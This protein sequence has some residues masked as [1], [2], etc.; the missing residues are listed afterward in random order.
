MG[1]TGHTEDGLAFEDIT[2]AEPEPEPEPEPEQGTINSAEEYEQHHLE[3][4]ETVMT[5]CG[6]ARQDPNNA[7]FDADVCIK[8]S[9][10]PNAGLG[11][12]A[13]RNFK[14][15]EVACIYPVHLIQKVK[16]GS[17]KMDL[18]C[19]LSNWIGVA[20][21]DDD[22]D[23]LK[24]KE[25]FTIDDVVENCHEYGVNVFRGPTMDILVRHDPTLPVSPK[26]YGGFLNDNGFRLG[27]VYKPE[28]NNCSLGNAQLNNTCRL[29]VVCTQDIKEGDELCHSY[30]SGYWFGTQEGENHTKDDQFKEKSRSWLMKREVPFG[31]E[32]KTGKKLWQP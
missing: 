32:V 24:R 10:I 28:N 21:G 15:G 30:G 11:V 31:L 17:E 14:N 6:A 3:I 7:I 19:R 8:E 20:D 16:N 1:N 5:G 23:W 26:Y 9:K 2:D 18:M 12:F 22:D 13:K 29:Q 27:K 25:E 4:C